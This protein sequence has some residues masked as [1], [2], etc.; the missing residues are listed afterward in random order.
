M[1]LSLLKKSGCSRIVIQHCKNVSKLAVRIAK[2]LQKKGY[3]VDLRLVEIGALLHDIGRSKTHSV[4]HAI[5]GAEIARSFA[6]PE[7]IVRII[8]RHVGAGIPKAEAKMLGWPEK[9]YMPET[10]EEKIVTYADKLIE[11]TKRVDIEETIA[12]TSEKLGKKHPAT[13]RLR[14]IQKEFES[15]L[16]EF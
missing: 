13:A 3:I 16:G 9:N 14:T 12:K 6:L 11:G 8:E 4:H 1:A 2:I 5:A 15:L 7:P 10:L